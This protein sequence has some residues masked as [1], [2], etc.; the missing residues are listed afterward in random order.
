MTKLIFFL[1]GPMNEKIL[2][3]MDN[4]YVSYPQMKDL[5]PHL[6]ISIQNQCENI[7]E[8]NKTR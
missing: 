7:D 5:S 3:S 8:R 1:H 6:T 4:I 2:N